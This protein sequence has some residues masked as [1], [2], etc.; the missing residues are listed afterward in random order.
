MLIRDYDFV[1]MQGDAPYVVYILECK[2]R[3]HYYVGKTK[4]AFNRINQHID[5][6]GSSFTKGYGVHDL[7]GFFRCYSEKQTNRLEE[8]LAKALLSVFGQEN[9]NGGSFVQIH[10]ENMKKSFKI[11]KRE[12]FIHMEIVAYYE[13]KDCYKVYRYLL[14]DKL[15]EEIIEVIDDIKTKK[16]ELIDGRK[17]ELSQCS[18]KAN[19]EPFHY[20]K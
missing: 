3:D 16:I 14:I 5:G 13:N 17:I 9:V 4:D 15:K 7:V 11:I 10:P 6:R 20:A 12:K 1:F 8:N 18:F 19:T 2:T